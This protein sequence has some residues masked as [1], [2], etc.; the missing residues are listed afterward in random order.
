MT[1]KGMMSGLVK[2]AV[3]GGVLGA[4]L[5]MGAPAR[6]EAQ[7]ISLGVE[8]GRP[9]VAYGYAAPPAYGYERWDWARREAT[10]R[11]SEEIEAR[12]AYEIRERERQ[13]AWRAHERHEAWERQRG[14]YGR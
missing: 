11:R 1:G 12:R 14:P 8:F 13:E 3:A 5:V 7:N 9:P 10:R 4:A 2:A 6:A